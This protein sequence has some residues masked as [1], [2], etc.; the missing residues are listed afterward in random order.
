MIIYLLVSS[1]IFL[2]FVVPIYLFIALF[3]HELFTRIKGFLSIFSTKKLEGNVIMFHGVSVGEIIAIDTLVKKTKKEIPDC[4]IVVTTGTNTGQD[5][6]N[7]QF[8][9]VADLITYFPPDFPPFVEY[10]LNKINPKK[11]VIAETEIWPNFSYIVNKKNIPLYIINGR[12]SDKSFKSYKRLKPF[13]KLFLGKTFSN[14]LAQSELDK[15]RF[16]QIGANP[17]GCEVMG[18][19]KFDIYPTNPEETLDKFDNKIMVVGSTHSGEEE[20]ILDVFK[21]VHAKHPNFKILLAPRHL[22]RLNEVEDLLD[23]TDFKYGAFSRNDSFK[24]NDIIVLDT[25][26][27]LAKMYFFAD[28]AY[29]GGSFCKT[30][31][32]NPLEATIYNK[33]V[34]SGHNVANFKDI[35]KVLTT[36][37]AGFIVNTKQEL[38]EQIL[39]LIED[40]AYYY[41]ICKNCENVFDANRGAIDRVIEK[42]KN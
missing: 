33:P 19:L 35:Y 4:K 1:V 22:T 42:L 16:L 10:F 39:K 41:S 5:V 15:E 30:G 11:V 7:K 37:N 29:I 18:N 27:Q 21:R 38:E 36:N 26:G 3:R 28:F 8:K 34:I 40:E 9:D 20:I 23:K 2:L 25:L 17:N 24:D 14:I 6:A 31:G 32:H 12:I 13:F